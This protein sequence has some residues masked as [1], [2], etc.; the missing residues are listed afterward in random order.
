MLVRILATLAAL[1]FGIAAFF[2]ASPT[3][4]QPNPF[5]IAF[6]AIAVGVWFGWDKI[7]AWSA[8]PGIF[9]AVGGNFVGRRGDAGPKV[10]EPD[11]PAPRR[12][13]GT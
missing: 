12:R 4:I 11:R 6:M 10:A 8:G 5:G 7:R 3:Q 2:G 13:S 9:D 1:G